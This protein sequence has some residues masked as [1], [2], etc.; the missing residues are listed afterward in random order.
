MSR[1]M[2]VLLLQALHAWLEQTPA[3]AEE[4]DHVLAEGPI[5]HALA[6]M[7]ASPEQDWSLDSLA[8]A[9]GMSRSLL[10][11]RFTEKVGEPPLAYLTRL[12]MD[13]ASKLLETTAEPIS[14]VAELVGYTSEFAFNRAF[15]RKLGVPPGRFRQQRGSPPKPD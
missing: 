7:R 2:E 14:R 3:R 15:E 12:R 5:G 13:I 1:L 10:A 9:V 8:M 4:R 6:L 11:R